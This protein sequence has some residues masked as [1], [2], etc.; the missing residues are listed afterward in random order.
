MDGSDC[1][2]GEA[3]MF[4]FSK[5]TPAARPQG[6]LRCSSCGSDETAQYPAS[7]RHYC[8][9]CSRFFHDASEVPFDV[10]ADGWT[11][12]LGALQAAGEIIAVRLPGGFYGL[13]VLRGPIGSGGRTGGAV[14][15]TVRP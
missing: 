6:H 9:R 15:C 7:A 11:P 13:C 1:T 12:A 3:F 14:R 5:R 4:T 8:F 10:V 2:E